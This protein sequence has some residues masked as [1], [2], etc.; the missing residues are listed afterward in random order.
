MGSTVSLTRGSC[1]IEPDTGQSLHGMSQEARA[2]PPYSLWSSAEVHSWG[3]LASL[4]HKSERKPSG[5]E[6]RCLQK[7]SAEVYRSGECLGV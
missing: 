4:P 2:L 3:H 5:G 7:D 1:A 6:N